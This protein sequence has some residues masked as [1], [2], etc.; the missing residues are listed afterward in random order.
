MGQQFGVIGLAVM[1]ENIALNIERNGFPIAVYNRTGAKTEAF[2]KGRGA[3]KNIVAAYTLPD[4]VHALDRPRKILIMVK[5]GAGT[6]AVIQQ[7]K[8]L[9]ED[10]DILIDG[11]N[12][13]Y[14]DTER[15]IEDL[16]GTGIR[17]FGMGISGG[18][19]GALKGPSIMPGGDAEA[20][21]EMEP[22]L[23]KIAAQTDTGPC[24]A[25]MG[26]RSAG[27]FV[28]MCHNGIEYGDMQL[29]AE[30][31]DLLR[32]GLGLSSEELE[33]VFIDWNESELQSYLIEI[34]SKIVN[35][36][37]DQGSGK[38]LVDCILD[39]AG[40]KGTGKWTT[41]AGLEL[42]VPVPTIT[43]A[44]DA[45][46]ISAMKAERVDAA[47]EYA[48]PEKTEGLDKEQTIEKVR[49]A[50]YASKICSYAQG[51]ALMRAASA[52][53]GYGLNY[54]EIA[55]IWKGGC[56]IRAVFLDRI[57]QA[58]AE[59]PDLANLLMAPTFKQDIEKR[60]EA[61]RWTIQ[62]AVDYGIAVPAM[63]ASIAYF[64]NYR[65]EQ[66]PANLI[67]AQRDFFGAH[68][69]ERVDREGIFHTQWYEKS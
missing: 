48:G 58:Y 35:F 17:Y 66:I 25:H 36:V 1:G 60:L 27:H 55:R 64:D 42:G 59:K 8:P 23:Q 67:Q 20:Y 3:G 50:L 34:T 63:S 44:V 45:R 57:R 43:A 7:L 18:E 10:G 9:L 49:A 31:Y 41:M 65:R 39:S 6:D 28:K 32:N 37:D 26:A 2:M 69:Y 16:R 29:I 11:G 47:K 52:E 38:S 30:V 24:V 68:T 13:Y 14:K 46:L 61:W 62:L 5:A 22:I 54:G 51:F 12:S 4:F 19:E 53:Y 21:A 15:R 40:Q 33:K 56:I